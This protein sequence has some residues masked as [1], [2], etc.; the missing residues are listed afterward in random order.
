MSKDRLLVFSLFSF[1]GNKNRPYCSDER[2]NFL[3]P[4]VRF[5][6][7][8]SNTHLVSAKTVVFCLFHVCIRDFNRVTCLCFQ[9]LVFL[10]VFC[11]FWP[12]GVC[13]W[14]FPLPRLRLNWG[15]SLALRSPEKTASKDL[16]CPVDILTL[17][18]YCFVPYAALLYACFLT[19]IG[20]I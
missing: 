18:I 11:F 8:C 13:F 4:V 14:F 12:G 17:L 9:S 16:S 2:H 15:L 7:F 20:N 1:K 5:L 6:Y 19:F 3:L 10:I